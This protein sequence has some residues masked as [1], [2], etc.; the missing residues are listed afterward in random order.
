MSFNEQIISAVYKNPTIWNPRHR[1]HKNKTVL[2]ALWKEISDTLESDVE[3]VK[4][5]WKGLKDYYRAEMKRNAKP[6]SDEEGGT[7]KTSVW[8]YFKLM[9]FLNDTM[10]TRE[11][12]TTLKEINITDSYTHFLVDSKTNSNSMDQISIKEEGDQDEPDNSETDQ[13]E[14]EIYDE[15]QYKEPNRSNPQ[16]ES[17]FAYV[18]YV[19]IPSTSNTKLNEEITEKKRKLST[20]NYR[21]KLVETESKKTKLHEKDGDEDDDLLFFK[22]LIPDFKLLPRTSKMSLR[23]KYQQLLYEETINLS[24]RSSII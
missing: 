6:P 10:R 20:D 8:P 2:S 15:S 13:Y 9:A 4:R 23:I 21:Q 11:R 17:A 3:T 14:G 18:E 16:S 12:G 7:S 19:D 24:N 1:D 22:S 5:K